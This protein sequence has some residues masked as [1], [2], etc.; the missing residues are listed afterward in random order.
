[1]K[2]ETIPFAFVPTERATSTIDQRAVNV[3]FEPIPSALTKTVY[4][5]CLK[6]PGLAQ[7]T[8]P[9]A[10]SAT[11]RGIYAWQATG[12][13]YSVFNNKIYSNTTDLG[14]TLAASSGRVWFAETPSTASAQL[15]V[16]SDGTD[17]YNITTGDAPTQIDE[18]DDAQYP[19]TNQGPI[20]Y[21]DGYL[22]QATSSSIVN[23]I[24]DNFTSWL[25]ADTVPV[26]G[27]G[28]SLE[29][30]HR[31]SDKII[32]FG[33]N[34]IEMYYNRGNPTGSPILRIDQNIRDFGI[35]TKNSLAWSGET[36]FFVG[37]NS[38]RGDGGRNVWMIAPGSV[39]EISTPV[40]NR[41]LAAEGSSM[42]SC[43]AWC[44]RIGGQ[45]VYVL[46]LSSAS[47]TFVYGVDTGMWCEWQTTDG[48]SK[49]SGA[50]ATSLN[51]TIYIQDATN[52]RVYT[53][54]P[55]TYQDNGSNFTVTVQTDTR[56]QGT[57]NRKTAIFAELEADTLAS[58]TATL[59][60]SDND[61]SSFETLGSFDMTKEQKRV[62]RCGSY[63]GKRIW[64]V[65]YSGNTAFRAKELR[66]GY[67]VEAR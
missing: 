67:T 1:M 37:E 33:K 47:R 27:Y 2:I 40:I 13:I 48:S 34:S 45:L 20:L 63:T 9:P 10:G 54:P 59:L 22:F 23:T 64:R 19:S 65:T 35:A 46:N 25:A 21:L 16:V 3:L 24:Y 4:L 61:G 62:W 44:E 14:V 11:A 8:Q 7:S 58:G 57:S 43:T 5:Q 50:Y 6:R 28:D 29:A 30:I 38:G 32:A 66:V 26:E 31:Q 42:S 12:K 15:L 60:K 56:D 41:F 52:G 39:K 18:N 53:M 51:G 36:I 49:F 17:N 55:T